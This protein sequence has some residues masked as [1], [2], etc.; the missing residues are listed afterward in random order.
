MGDDCLIRIKGQLGKGKTII[1]LHI[2][3]S[4]ETCSFITRSVRRVAFYGRISFVY[5]QCD[6]LDSA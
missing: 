1:F 2:A 3:A 4:L 5:C 6:I